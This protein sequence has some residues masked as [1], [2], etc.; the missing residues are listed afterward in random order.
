MLTFIAGNVLVLAT[1]LA[2]AARLARYQR[3]LAREWS[4]VNARG[5]PDGTRHSP[6]RRAA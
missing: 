4:N 5:A 2:Y 6:V 1:M 3:R